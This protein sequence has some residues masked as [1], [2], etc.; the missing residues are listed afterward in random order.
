MLPI[1]FCVEYVWIVP[2]HTPTVAMPPVLL[3]IL[4]VG[5]ALIVIVLVD[6]VPLQPRAV[7]V[8]LTLPLPTV[9]HCTVT[10]TPVVL[11][12]TAPPVTFQL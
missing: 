6:E 2:A 7:S 8:T 9:F 5:T 1:L 4:G 12:C 10:V 11:P 3:V